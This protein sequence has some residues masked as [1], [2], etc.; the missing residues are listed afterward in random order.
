MRS[1]DVLMPAAASEYGAVAAEILDQYR[2]AFTARDMALV[3]RPW[4]QGPGANEN[5]GD[6]TLALFAWGYHLDVARWEA[7]LAAWPAERLLLNA[8]P[9]LAWNTRKTYLIELEAKGIPIVPS[10]F[11]RADAA[12]VAA[13]FEAFGAA[14]LVV[15]PQV[16]GGSYRT[17]RVKP[18]D[19]VEPLDDA[20]IQPFIPAV[21]GEGELSFLFIGGAFRHAVRKV[22]KQGDFRIQPQ[23]GGQ[24][25]RFEPEAAQLALAET[26]IAALPE[27]SLYARVDLL[28]L[29][30][31]SLALMELEAIEPDLYPHMA[32]E[33]PARLAD[34]V[35]ARL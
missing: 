32:P 25:S 6:A 27:A 14:E 16:S 26:V 30:D 11:G 15:K 5:W 19:A 35:A 3:T 4:D 8:A 2:A 24:F 21:S 28:R 20:I 1:I 34:A 23:F 31:G 22:A 18:G 13:A 10:R 12:S 33:L 7:M 17:V 9:L 29:A